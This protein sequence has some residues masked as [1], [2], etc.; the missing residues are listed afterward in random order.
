MNIGGVYWVLNRKVDKTQ[1]AFSS[2]FLHN[3]Y[4]NQLKTS[5]ILEKISPVHWIAFEF[6]TQ[7][8]P[9]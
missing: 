2:K 6:D 9:S 1:L 4:A 3:N 8:T 7:R 5:S